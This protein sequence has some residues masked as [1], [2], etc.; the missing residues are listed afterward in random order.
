MPVEDAVEHWIFA[1]NLESV[2]KEPR[3]W[4][5]SVVLDTALEEATMP[6][7]EKSSRLR[8]EA[9]VFVSTTNTKQTT[10][11]AEHAVGATF[12]A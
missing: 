3:K 5:I 8:G 9:G 7:Y 4:N 2:V 11:V 6:M 10:D 12:P 1:S